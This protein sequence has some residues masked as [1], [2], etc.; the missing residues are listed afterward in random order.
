MTAGQQFPRPS[1]SKPSPQPAII[2]ACQH[3]SDG[4]IEADEAS[5]EEDGSNEDNMSEDEGNKEDDEEDDDSKQEHTKDN[6]PTA[7][8]MS[9][10]GMFVFFFHDIFLFLI[11]LFS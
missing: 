11:S 5:Q 6:A 3:Q 8:A 2:S 10:N 1:T 4:P 7:S 9:V